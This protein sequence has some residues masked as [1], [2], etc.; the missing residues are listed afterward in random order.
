MRTVVFSVFISANEMLRY[1]RGTTKTVIVRTED[2]LRV[3]FPAYLL[4]P[5]MTHSGVRGRFAL[6]FDQHNRST[7]LWRLD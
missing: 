5:H 4:R 7:G 2:G 3:G 6:Q 1:Y